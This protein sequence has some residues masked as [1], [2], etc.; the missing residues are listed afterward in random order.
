MFTPDDDG[1]CEKHESAVKT[2]PSGRQVRVPCHAAEKEHGN[3]HSDD[4]GDDEGEE[5]PE[6]ETE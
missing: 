4:S 6:A 2:T 5:T 1:E 3:K